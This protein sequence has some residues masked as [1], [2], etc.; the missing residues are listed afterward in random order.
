M[1]DD[2]NIGELWER[3]ATTDGIERGDTLV[4]IGGH[5]LRHGHATEALAAV[6]AAT[7]LYETAGAGATGELAAAHH[8]AA[9]VLQ[10]LGRLEEAAERHERAVGAHMRR[11]RPV[12]AAHCL[13]HTGDL[14]AMIPEPA[15]AL[16]RYDEAA[17][18]FDSE[19]EP[20]EAG[21]TLVKAAE[22]ALAADK[23]GWAR[24]RVTKARTLLD[25][26]GDV[27]G[28]GRCELVAARLLRRRHR[29]EAALDAVRR[30]VALLDSVGDDVAIADALVLRVELLADAGLADEA[31]ALADG[32][33]VELREADDPE[34][35]A[36]CDLAAGRALL[37]LG[38]QD[39]ATH[40]L[41]DAATVLAAIGRID[42]A[43]AARQ[44]IV[45]DGTP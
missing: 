45:T 37:R 27:R 3:V 40:V 44:L 13:R 6:D 7:D 22:A 17:A 43:D 12:E 19:E 24:D 20:G 42:D 18:V 39:R 10:V 32:L 26:L 16:T 11:W 5:L 1:D 34:R 9:V 2:T 31:V 25:P 21:H 15:D 30:A 41:E 38:E 23:P 29:P 14:L 8:N 28:I 4:E 35:V 36:R 33:R